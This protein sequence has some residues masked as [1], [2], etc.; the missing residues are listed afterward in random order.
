MLSVLALCGCDDGDG[1]GADGGAGD[2]GAADAMLDGGPEGCSFEELAG[3]PKVR[4]PVGTTYWLPTPV[5]CGDA[6]WRLEDQMGSV[7]GGPVVQGAD[8]VARYTPVTAGTVRFE[9]GDTGQTFDITAVDPT[10]WSFHNYNYYPSTS[11][12]LVDGALWVANAYSPTISVL[13]PQS[14]ELS[15]RIPVGGWPVAL[16][17]RAGM[18]VAL[19]AHRAD[20]TVGFVNLDAQ[21]LLDAVWVGDEPSNLL[22][23]ADGTRAWVSL[24]TESAVAEIDVPARSVIRRIEVA[25]EPFAM[26]L[27][28]D[29]STLY[30]ATQRSGQ[31][32]RFPY[33]E[34]PVENER[35]IAV[36]D[37]AAGTVSRWMLDVG[38]TINSMQVSAD[39]G[40]LYVAASA[41]DN[42]ADFV[43]EDA[44]NFRHRVLAID[45]ETDAIRAEAD[46]SR[47]ASSGGFAVSLHGL[48][49]DPEGLLWVAAEASDL[50]IGL[51]PTDLSEQV[52]ADA[53]GRPRS[54]ILGDDRV[55]VHGNQGFVVH[56]FDKTGAEQASGSTGDDPRPASV[57]A[58]QR[59]FSG[60]G[61]EFAQN[62]GCDSCHGEAR[63]DTVVWKAG[64]FES[65]REATR[66]LFWLEGTYPLGWGGYVRSPRNFAF[67][68]NTNVGIRPNTDE[69]EN[70]ADYLE[71][72]MPPP[73]A[74]G[75]TRRD[76]ALSDQALSGKA[77]YDGKAAC[78]GCHPLPL[79]TSRIQLPDGI[80]E[81]K[82]D[83]PSLVGAYRHNVWLKHGDVQTMRDAIQAV[84]DRNNQTLTDAEIEDLTRYT[85]ELTA[86]DF[87]VLAVEPRPDERVP[88]N[89]P[90]RVIFNLPVHAD[91]ANLARVKLMQGDAEVAV[92][93]TLEGRHV[94]LTPDAPLDHATEYAVVVDE[95]F[96]SRDERLL[97]AAER[98]TLNTG[99]APALQLDGEYVW[100]IDLPVPD[101]PNDRFNPEVT[102]P[103]T[104]T[105]IA[106]AQAPG[107]LIVD[108]GEDLV[109][110]TRAVVDGS[111]LKIPSLLV[112]VT[113]SFSDTRGLEVELVDTDDDG[114]ADSGEG[115]LVMLGPGF[116]VPDVRFTLGRPEAPPMEC[117]EGQMGDLPIVFERDEEGR[118]VFAWDDPE[119][120]ALGFYVTDPGATLPLGPGQTVSGG[121]A[122]WALSTIEFPAGFEGPITYGVVPAGAMDASEMQGAP[123]GGAELEA[124]R[125]YQF[126]VITNRFQTASWTV[127]W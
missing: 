113:Q 27:S 67:A 47:Q 84:L 28:P 76:G 83:I 55:Y 65:A 109:Y 36:V 89:R 19:V 45:T 7:Q 15:T 26:A 104:S 18:D 48:A 66:P 4:L 16:G 126:S 52:R 63:T 33:G 17:W 96:E 88:V 99:A 29:E 58:G 103:V 112:A 54:V 117:V 9:L 31:T 68:T 30:V 70:L 44:P 92:S 38:T 43:D 11:Q 77:L 3:Q 13:D 72:L 49:L 85:L 41:T 78:G 39:G 20:D 10:G 64:P 115:V 97:F 90:I 114:I 24:A 59:Y 50:V 53:P 100:T 120:A 57:A 14:L 61:R 75:L 12:A 87:F 32:G 93:R 35:D 71:S 105:F 122:Y 124:G 127:T 73:A 40:T 101:F 23:N 37:L 82:S 1:G 56:A 106:D 125:C 2:G 118:P 51:D 81:G 25:V 34:D 110:A 22:L 91:E 95:G 42:V 98:H 79:T 116:E 5:N 46:L 102:V 123:A 121:A 62:W 80:T 60:T 6:Q 107:E 8:G 108:Y 119:Q 21:Q 69:A 111:T 74:N 86:R 94:V